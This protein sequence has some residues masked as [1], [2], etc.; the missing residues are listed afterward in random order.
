MDRGGKM[1]L[2]KKKNNTVIPKENKKGR[3]TEHKKGMIHKKKVD[4]NS[5]LLF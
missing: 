5:H 3:K 4:L 2:K 1:E